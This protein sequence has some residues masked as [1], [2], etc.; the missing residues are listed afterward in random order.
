[1]WNHE[2]SGRFF[3][4][5]RVFC[6]RCRSTQYN[7]KEKVQAHT[8]GMKKIAACEREQRTESMHHAL[9][10]EVSST[11]MTSSR[12]PWSREKYAQTRR[13]RQDCF[14][15]HPFLTIKRNLHPEN[16]PSK[17]LHL[18]NGATSQASESIIED[19]PG[20]GFRPLVGLDPLMQHDTRRMYES[21]PCMADKV[22]TRWPGS[23]SVD[24]RHVATG[25]VTYYLTGSGWM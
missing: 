20:A 12:Y 11:N 17:A 25:R 15:F 7:S 18:L 24:P 23:F 8:G 22:E 14:S 16:V 4:R 19:L 3:R 6:S 5:E 10:A 2:C 1:M 21:R 13:I 9:L